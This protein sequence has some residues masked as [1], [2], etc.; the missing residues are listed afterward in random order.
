MIQDS[1]A[2]LDPNDGDYNDDYEKL[3]KYKNITCQTD[4]GAT[5]VEAQTVANETVTT[6]TIAHTTVTTP[7]V[8]SE[9]VTTQDFEKTSVTTKNIE[10][11]FLESF[12]SLSLIIFCTLLK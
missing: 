4:V 12:L 6:Q 3:Q 1:I 11:G 7:T 5:T 8:V 10:N 2:N 9:T